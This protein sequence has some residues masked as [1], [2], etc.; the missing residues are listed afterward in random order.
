MSPILY[1]TG[2]ITIANLVII[3][4]GLLIHDQVIE[5]KS[6]ITLMRNDENQ[7]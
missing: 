2:L 7:F 4:M 1:L 5:L 3:L 6:L